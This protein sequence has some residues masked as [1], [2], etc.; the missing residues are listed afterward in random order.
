MAISRVRREREA[1]GGGAAALFA[2]AFAFA[3]PP[4]SSHFFFV[5]VAIAS[6]SGPQ[7]AVLPHYLHRHLLSRLDV[8]A[9]LH[10]GIGAL[11]CLFVRLFGRGA[12]C[13]EEEEGEKRRRSR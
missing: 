10:L 2:F 8:P 4:P 11:I 9:V 1:E 6:A 12:S 13:K 7:H 5:V 3:F